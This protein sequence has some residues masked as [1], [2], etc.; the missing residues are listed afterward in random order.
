MENS[1]NYS[2]IFLVLWLNHFHNRKINKKCWRHAMYYYYLIKHRDTYWETWRKKWKN[3][4]HKRVKDKSDWVTSTCH[5]HTF[6]F[7]LSFVLWKEFL[8]NEYFAAAFVVHTLSRSTFFLFCNNITIKVHSR[9]MC[10]GN[11]C[12]FALSIVP[13]S[14]SPWMDSLAFSWCHTTNDKHI[15]KF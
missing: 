8:W 12:H 3:K 11:C 10:Y 15:W 4:K 2:S 14:R 9:K 13:L 6:L 7:L 5:M 1:F